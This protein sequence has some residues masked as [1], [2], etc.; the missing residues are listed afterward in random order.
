MTSKR[1]IIISAAAAAAAIGL[2]SAAVVTFGASHEAQP[3]PR[4]EAQLV[5]VAVVK[6]ATASERTFTGLISA[7]VQSNLGFRV[8]GKVLERYVEV[9]Q[10]VK[11]GQPLM[12]IDRTDLNLALAARENTAAA[13]RALAVQA[14]ADE[15]RYAKLVKEGW[16]TAQRYDQAKAA[17]DNA[18]GQLSAAEAQAEVARNEAG[19]SVLPA[20]VDGTVVETLAE[21]GQVVAAGQTVVR[22]A[23]AG[24]REASV[25][26]PETMRPKLGSRAEATVY[27][28]TTTIRS[29]ARLRE[30]SDAAD[31]ATRT[32][33]A[34]YVLDGE[35]A[36]APLGATVTVWIAR[37]GASEASEVPLG[38]L[39]DDGKASGVWVLD[40]G[41]TSVSFRPVKVERLAQE[42]AIVTGVKS[43]EQVVALGAHLLH[44]DAKVRVDGARTAAR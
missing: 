15:K 6:P 24:A 13:A 39:L 33:E 26:L 9:G 10:T 23:K 2:V 44:S 19:Y 30:L 42:T 34:R 14:A 7:R 36:R 37:D 12:R 25:D 20:D 29:P 32:Y 16:V 17:L 43:G 4:Q 28:T 11:A 21:P 27:G 35:A 22:L 1:T 5:E 3:D 31:P 18:N 41:G 40:P 8:A 38:A